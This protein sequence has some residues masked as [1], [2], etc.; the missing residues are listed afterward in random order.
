[1]KWKSII[2]T[3]LVPLNVFLLFV[4]LFENKLQVPA[5]LQVIGRLHPAIFAFSNRVNFI[6]CALAIIFVREFPE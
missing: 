1:M 3:S 5:W 6:I 2:A 4:L